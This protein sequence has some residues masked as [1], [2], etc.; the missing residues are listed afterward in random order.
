MEYTKGTW[1]VCGCN[2]EKHLMVDIHILGAGS[3]EK[4][5]VIATLTY[6][7]KGDA[8]LISAAPDMYGALKALV[9]YFDVGNEADRPVII[10]GREALAKAEGKQH[11]TK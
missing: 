4:E 6:E 3:T 11:L 10:K 5:Q 2:D 7:H 1:K 8:Y 9:N